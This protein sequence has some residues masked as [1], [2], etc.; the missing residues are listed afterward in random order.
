METTSISALHL[1]N[2][3]KIRI[4]E[5]LKAREYTGANYYNCSIRLYFRVNY[6][7]SCIFRHS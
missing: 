7:L 5:I 6:G 4:E 3:T 2:T 1:I